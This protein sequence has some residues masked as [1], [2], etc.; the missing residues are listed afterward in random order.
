MSSD[1]EDAKA[2][3]ERFKQMEQLN[4]KLQDSKRRKIAVRV[5]STL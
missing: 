1:N 4:D 3:Q 5:F 2:R